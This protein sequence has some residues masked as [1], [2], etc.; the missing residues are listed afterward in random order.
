MALF[1]A[2]VLLVP[3]SVVDTSLGMYV[4]VADLVYEFLPAP[5]LPVQDIYLLCSSKRESKKKISNPSNLYLSSILK[6]MSQTKY[7]SMKLVIFL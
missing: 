4:L 1:K 2:V 6:P 3:P 7:S 5:R